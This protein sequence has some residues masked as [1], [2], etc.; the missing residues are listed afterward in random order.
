MFNIGDMSMEEIKII[1]GKITVPVE[2]QVDAIVDEIQAVPDREV[3]PVEWVIE[4]ST[5]DVKNAQIEVAMAMEDKAGVA[6]KRL[7]ETMLLPEAP[8]VAAAA[9]GAKSKSRAEFVVPPSDQ[10]LE[11]PSFTFPNF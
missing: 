3:T 6:C 5:N 11:L 7:E 2:Q 8:P 4:N 1:S 10:K 9:E